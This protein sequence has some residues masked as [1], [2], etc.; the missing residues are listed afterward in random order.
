MRES[1]AAL[2]ARARQGDSAAYGTLIQRY[3]H[4][5]YAVALAGLG[6]PA[7]AED[8]CQDSFVTAL[9]RIEECRQPDQFGA[10]LLAIVRNRARDYRRYRAVRFAVPLEDDTAASLSPDPEREAERAELRDDLLMALEVLTD[11]QREVLLLFDLEG[12]SHREIAEKLGISPESARVHLHNGRKA[13][14]L[15]L[16]GLHEEE[17]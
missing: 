8:V 9:K 2:V 5:A 13:L 10:W 15:R 12:W 11:T 4:P 1:D 6:E 7:D 17:R 16:A 14:R 3:L